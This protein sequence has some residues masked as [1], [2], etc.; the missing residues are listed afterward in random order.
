MKTKPQKL[1]PSTQQLI[2]RIELAQIRNAIVHGAITP[3]ISQL[4]DKHYSRFLR[5]AHT[6]PKSHHPA[7]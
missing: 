4:L 5:A 7:R 3:R 6:L 1:K 2:E